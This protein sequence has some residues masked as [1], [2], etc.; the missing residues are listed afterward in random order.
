VVS[1]VTFTRVNRYYFHVT[2]SRLLDAYAGDSH[3]AHDGSRNHNVTD[4]QLC[5]DHRE[6]CIRMH[7]GRCHNKALTAST[8][9]TLTNKQLECGPMPNLMVALPNIGGALCSTPQ[10]LADAPY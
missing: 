9:I 5:P 2:T 4:C 6:A 1:Y 3:V 8:I 10:S 7:V